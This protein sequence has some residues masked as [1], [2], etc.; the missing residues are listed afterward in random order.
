M[1]KVQKDSNNFYCGGVQGWCED[2]AIKN[3]QR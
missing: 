2:V 1:I 3:Q